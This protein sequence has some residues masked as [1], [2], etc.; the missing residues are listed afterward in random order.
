MEL[1]GVSWKPMTGTM[2]RRRWLQLTIDLTLD[3][4]KSPL[5]HNRCQKSCLGPTLNVQN[6]CMIGAHVF[7]PVKM[8]F[9]TR[10]RYQWQ[11]N[12]L[13][14]QRTKHL[15]HHSAQGF[16]LGNKTEVCGESQSSDNYSQS[17]VHLFLL[18][19]HLLVDCSCK[20]PAEALEA[21]REA[22]K[23]IQHPLVACKSLLGWGVGK[24]EHE[25]L[26][27]TQRWMLDNRSFNANN[28]K[29]ERQ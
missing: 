17:H 2:T 11:Y 22:A 4:S 5:Q 27:S 24:T 19:L 3:C 18:V 10:S 26:C 6:K 29:R 15:K 13:Q 28:K 12:I 20:C 21:T 9:K 7:P 14:L 16:A 8:L 1:P 25:W 23:K